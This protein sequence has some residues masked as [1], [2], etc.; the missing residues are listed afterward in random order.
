MHDCMCAYCSGQSEEQIKSQNFLGGS[1]TQ[2]D[3]N[4]PKSGNQFAVKYVVNHMRFGQVLCTINLVR[5]S[6]S[7]CSPFAEIDEWIPIYPKVQFH[8]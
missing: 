8:C 1:V 2:P 4:W 6:P 5:H 3:E 7:S